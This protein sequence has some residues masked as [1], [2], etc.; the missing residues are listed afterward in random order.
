MMK[1]SESASCGLGSVCVGVWSP[2]G[3]VWGGSFDEETISSWDS[4]FENG[5]VSCESGNENE[6][7]GEVSLSCCPSLFP[8][9]LAFPLSFESSLVKDP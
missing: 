5:S 4:V 1:Q 7:D 9:T 2:W 8:G 6:S 3:H